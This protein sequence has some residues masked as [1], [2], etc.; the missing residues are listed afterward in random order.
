VLEADGVIGKFLV[1]ERESPKLMWSVNQ[2]LVNEVLWFEGFISVKWRKEKERQF[3]SEVQEA[4]IVLSTI[5]LR[6]CASEMV[7]DYGS[8]YI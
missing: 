7:N 8:K 6:E 5:R 4:M 2:I 3:L 1:F